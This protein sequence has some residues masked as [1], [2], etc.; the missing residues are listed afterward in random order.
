MT[1]S[2]EPSCSYEGCERPHH[3]KGRCQ[4]HYVRER[5]RERYFSDPEYRERQIQRAMNNRRARVARRRAEQAG[6]ADG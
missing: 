3:A 5:N 1:E 2:T 4:V 6:H